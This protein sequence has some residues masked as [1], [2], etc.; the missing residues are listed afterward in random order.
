[1][2][3]RI[4]VEG[5]PPHEGWWLTKSAA[6][7]I[8]QAWR[9]WDGTCWSIPC[10]EGESADEAEFWATKATVC[11]NV[12]WCSYWPENGR[13]PRINPHTGEVTGRIMEP[14]VADEADQEGA[15]SPQDLDEGDA[16]AMKFTGEAT[17]DS[18]EPSWTLISLGVFVVL[19]AV[20]LAVG[21]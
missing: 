10:H 8:N 18:G 11:T 3:E 6:S 19:L 5:Y 16:Y 20:A 13:V 21:A 9:W 7:T 15:Q 2:S 17:P 12:L 14:Q 4:W 1:M